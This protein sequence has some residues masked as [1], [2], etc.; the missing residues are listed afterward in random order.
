MCVS[1]SDDTYGI[2]FSF[3]SCRGLTGNAVVLAPG[4]MA[5]EVRITGEGAAFTCVVMFGVVTLECVVIVGDTGWD[6][7]LPVDR[8]EGTLCCCCC[9]CC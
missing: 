8:F 2:A 4:L 5:F 1:Q 7:M 9:C 3:T 6:G